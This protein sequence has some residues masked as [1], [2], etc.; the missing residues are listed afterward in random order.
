MSSNGKVPL[1]ILYTRIG[2]NPVAKRNRFNLLKKYLMAL[3]YWAAAF[4]LHTPGLSLHRQIIEHAIRL[5]LAGAGNCTGYQQMVTLPLDSVR[6]FEF[7]FLWRSVAGMESGRRYLDISSPRLFPMMLL[8]SHPQFTAD[9]VNPDLKDLE[10]TRE[11]FDVCELSGRCCFRGELAGELDLL[12]ESYDLITSISVIEHIPGSGDLL[13]V[14]KMWQLLKPG[15]R[16]LLSVPC[17]EQA[18]EEYIDYDEYQLL[19]ADQEKFVF[20]QRF[21]HDALLRE[22]IFAVTGPPSRMEVY[23]EKRFGVCIANREAKVSDPNYPFWREPYLM[24]RQ[25]SYFEAIERLPGW[26]VVA[27]EFRKPS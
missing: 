21:Y 9:L 3:P 13:A 26:G 17:A 12:P 25:F 23:G 24:G 18:F 14:E 2:R 4:W 11:L 6:Y 19:D 27:M 1:G 20:G 10:V 15:G 5:R 8:Q 22:R 16:L 7:D